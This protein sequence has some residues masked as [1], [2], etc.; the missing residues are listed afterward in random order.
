MLSLFTIL[1]TG[2]LR[3]GLN[4]G[5]VAL[6]FDDGPNLEGNVTPD[7]LSVLRQNSVKAGFCVVG[8]QVRR[9]PD[10]VRRMYRAGHLLINHTEHHDHPVRQNLATLTAEV[11]SCDRAIGAALGRSDY[12]SAYFRAPFG[13]VTIAVRRLIRLR[14]MQPVLLSHYGWDTRVGPHNYGPVV[15]R[16]I[17]NAR[18]YRGGM[19]VF[20]DG[21]LCPP[22]ISEKDWSRSVENRSWVPEAVARVITELKAEGLRFVIPGRNPVTEDSCGPSPQSRAA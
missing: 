1:R 17:E 11:D 8:Q 2:P 22:K 21:S 15:D 14:G 6:T 3:A 18:R 7:L 9:H 20:H 5:E 10:V 4:P 19:Y 16:I 13:I 12:H